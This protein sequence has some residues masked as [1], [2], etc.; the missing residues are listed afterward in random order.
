MPHRMPGN[1]RNTTSGKRLLP[2]RGFVV[3]AGLTLIVALFSLP[4]AATEIQV[5]IQVSPITNVSS[6]I[7]AFDLTP[8][9]GPQSNIATIS[10]FTTDGTLG[11]PGPTTG[12]VSGSLPGTV[13]L[14]TAGIGSSSLNEYLTGITL[15]TS[16]SFDL[17]T[18]DNAP[19]PSSFPDAFSL[20]IL[21]PTLLQPIFS[22]SDPSGA[23]TLMLFNID[24]SGGT[25]PG[26]LNVY[27][28][29]GFKARVAPVP[30]PGT[31]L[32]VG[33]GVL[34][35]FWTQRKLNP[36]HGPAPRHAHL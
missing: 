21:D 10:G 33:V 31:L 18:T 24:G 27:T 11:A 25:A 3:S 4:A 9:G 28:G 35:L 15:G 13:T 2:V 22:T 17:D 30:E 16:F 20:S 34:A 1:P 36:S 26:A 23:N 14:S 12:N 6:E 19:G 29:D 7:L 5:T 32:L 8:G